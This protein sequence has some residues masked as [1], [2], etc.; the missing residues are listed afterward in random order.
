[1]DRKTLASKARRH[2]EEHLPE[3]TQKLKESGQFGFAIRDAAR[4]AQGEIGDLIA[5]GYQADE[6]ERLILLK[7]IFL[8]PESQHCC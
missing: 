2:W 6:A 5:Q 7:Y 3:A 1:M 8:Q 4:R